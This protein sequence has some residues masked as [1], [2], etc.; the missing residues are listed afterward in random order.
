VAWLSALSEVGAVYSTL[1]LDEVLRRIVDAAVSLTG[2]DEGF[3]ALLDQHSGQLYLRAAKNINQDQIETM[4]LPVTVPAGRVL[5]PPPL[6]LAS[7][8]PAVKSAPATWP[9]PAARSNSGQMPLGVLSVM[10]HLVPERRLAQLTAITPVVE[11]AT[12]TRARQELTTRAGRGCLRESEERYALAVGGANDGLWDWDMRSN[13]IY[14]SPRWK[15]MLGYEDNELSDSLAEWFQRVHSDDLGQLKMNI[16]SHIKGQTEHF[17]CEYR[18]RHKDGSTRWMLSRG[19]AIWGADGKV[20]RMAG[21]Q[22]DITPRK[23][24]EQRLVHDALYDSLTG[25]PNRAL[26]MDRLH[27]AIEHARRR[28][29]TVRCAVHESRPLQRRQRQPGPQTGDQLLRPP[30]AC[31]KPPCVRWTRWRAG[32]R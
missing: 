19:V 18:I 9:Q 1:D 25:L 23:L 4:R 10:P 29:T 27:Q 24:F 20:H 3:L 26:F 14:Y 6:R 16:S 32:R 12:C 28:R 11:N 17:E 31:W 13:R 15:A 8:P 22:T 21:S 2:A 5:S 30:P 7:R